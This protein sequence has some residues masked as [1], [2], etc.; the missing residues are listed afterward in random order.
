MIPSKPKLYLGSD[1]KAAIW[2]FRAQVENIKGN[3]PT[4]EFE[5]FG[6]P[7]YHGRVDSPDF[8]KRYRARKRF[9]ESEA[10]K[11]VAG[12]ILSDPKHAAQKLQIPEV[13]R[14][15]SLPEPEPSPMLSEC[16][17]WFAA[18]R[19]KITVEEQKKVRGAW[20]SFT[21]SVAPAITLSDVTEKLFDQWVDVCWLPYDDGG[22]AYTLHH[23]IEKV[24]RVIKYVQEKKGRDPQSC[25]RLRG[26]ITRLELPPKKG[27]PPNPLSVTEWN[28]LYE[29]SKKTP[30]EPMLVTM[31]NCCFYGCDIRR[32]P[33]ASLDLKARTLCFDREKKETPRVAVLWK[34]TAD[35]LKKWMKENPSNSETVFVSMYRTAYA[36]GGLRTAFR[37]FRE[38]NK[39]PETITLNRVRDSA[40][41]AGIKGGSV[42][43]RVLAGHKMQGET[44]AYVRRNPELTR[45]AVEA[46]ERFYFARKK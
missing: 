16:L 27:S 13:A 4:V 35:L 33:V 43:A 7:Q 3:E 32:L 42:A 40:Y 5:G 19:R 36:A 41:T 25:E 17:D 8:G 22:S 30:W 10:Y 20:N 39:L 46:I 29:A 23:A 12:K 45:P 21:K 34:R 24:K 2:R 18:K 44:D 1:L 31:L 15:H 6:P 37:S 38:N 11:F 14:L 28:R 9:P 26:W